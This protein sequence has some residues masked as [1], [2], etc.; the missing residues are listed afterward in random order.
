MS[1][2]KD[3]GMHLVAVDQEGRVV[4][5]WDGPG[6]LLRGLMAMLTGAPSLVAALGAACGFDRGTAFKLQ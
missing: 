4:A 5:C 2:F 3:D 1:E 6:D